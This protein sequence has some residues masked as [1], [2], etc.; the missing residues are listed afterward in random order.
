MFYFPHLLM[1][2]IRKNIFK[3]HFVHKI[4]KLINFST[5]CLNENARPY[6][7]DHFNILP[8]RMSPHATC[9]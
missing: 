7:D 9:N 2:F 1:L 8:I 5:E 3:G 6:F 4:A